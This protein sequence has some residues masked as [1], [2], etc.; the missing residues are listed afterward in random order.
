ML[1]LGVGLYM[2]PA[3]LRNPTAENAANEKSDIYSVGMLCRAMLCG[4]PGAIARPSEGSRHATV[5]CDAVVATATD[6]DQSRRFKTATDLQRC[7]GLLRDNV[8]GV[9]FAEK[10]K[11]IAHV[12]AT[13]LLVCL[14]LA[15]RN[16]IWASDTGIMEITGTLLG[17][18]LVSWIMYVHFRYVC[19]TCDHLL[20]EREQYTYTAAA[21]IVW[22]ESMLCACFSP[23]WR[24]IVLYAGMALLGGALRSALYG[25][26][27]NQRKAEDSW[28]MHQYG[29]VLYGLCGVGCLLGF[30]AGRLFHGDTISI[31]FYDIFALF[32]VVTAHRSV[33]ATWQRHFASLSRATNWRRVLSREAK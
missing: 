32:F 26:S 3:F 28:R 20:D 15:V 25:R 19:H 30:G 22:A 24:Y 31:W 7:F 2:D 17:A 10:G 12:M 5:V 6:L 18:G 4:A 21:V 13:T 14:G 27:Q 1:V 8:G 23:H 33:K 11:W 9:I 16:G 29:I